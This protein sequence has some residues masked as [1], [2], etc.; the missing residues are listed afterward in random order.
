LPPYGF[1]PV[2][3]WANAGPAISIATALMQNNIIIFY[4]T[5]RALHYHSYKRFFIAVL[6]KAVVT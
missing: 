3:P 1:A 2:V 6:S 5:Q 4:R